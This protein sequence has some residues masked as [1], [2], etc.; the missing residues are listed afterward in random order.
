MGSSDPQ[1]AREPYEGRWNR[2]SCRSRSS[3]AAIA[4]SHDGLN[5]FSAQTR[6]RARAI[7]SL[8][9]CRSARLAT[10]GVTRDLGEFAN[11]SQLSI[12]DD[13]RTRGP[14][15]DGGA[16]LRSCPGVVLTIQFASYGSSVM[17]PSHVGPLTSS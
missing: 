7:A 13:H 8:R 14:S 10:C 16:V 12:D 1:V 5:A 9:R 6:S 3:R 15:G 17:P 2:L 11:M 4:A